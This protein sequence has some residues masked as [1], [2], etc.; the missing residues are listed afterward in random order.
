RPL[1][2]LTGGALSPWPGVFAVH[3]LPPAVA[4]LRQIALLALL[5]FAIVTLSG[6]L[7]AVASVVLSLALGILSFALVGFLILAIV[8]ALYRG[9]RAAWEG[10]CQ[11]C[12][13][14]GRIG[15]RLLHTLFRLFAF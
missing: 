12:Q 15:Q 5:G 2:P 1:E 9:Q 8:R 4:A 10:V 11:V 6:P 7:V 3:N 14:L 13:N